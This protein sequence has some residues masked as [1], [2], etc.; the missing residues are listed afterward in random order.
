[1]Y[2]KPKRE[3]VKGPFRLNRYDPQLSGCKALWLFNEGA[4]DTIYNHIRDAHHGIIQVSS[5]WTQSDDGLNI[6]DQGGLVYCPYDDELADLTHITLF[7]EV[8]NL[9]NGNPKFL[10]SI[11][12]DNSTPNHIKFD[13][14][15]GQADNQETDFIV[16]IGG[17]SAG[18]TIVPPNNTFT[19]GD[20]YIV[21][22]VYDGSGERMY[23]KSGNGQIYSTTS[24]KTGT[25][26]HGTTA[27]L[28][29]GRSKTSDS[30]ADVILYQTRLYDVGLEESAIHGILDDYYRPFH[31]PIPYAVI[32]TGPTN[33]NVT[34]DPLTTIE[35]ISGNSIIAVNVDASALPTV[36]SLSATQSTVT[37]ILITADA[38]ASLE[39]LAGN[40]IISVNKTPTAL[41][42]V[43]SLSGVGSTVTNINI[44]ADSLISIESITGDFNTSVN[45]TAGVLSSIESI[46][47]TVQAGAGVNITADPLSS[48]E[49]IT[50]TFNT[51]VLYSA[52][53]LNSTESLNATVQIGGTVNV[54]ADPLISVESINGNVILSVNQTAQVLG[55][56]ES[57]A[58]SQFVKVDYSASPLGTIESINANNITA[59]YKIANP[60]ETTEYIN[61]SVSGEASITA[62]P[63]E[64]TESITGNQIIGVFI[65]AS[66]MSTQ[67]ALSGGYYTSVYKVGALSTTESL[68]GI[69]IGAGPGSLGQ[70]QH[71]K[72]FNNLDE[73]LVWEPGSGFQVN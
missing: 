3:K 47:G 45:Q 44:T 63:L 70:I 71:V 29:F 69:G 19:L 6:P 30:N 62:D 41:S 38:L 7:C 72:L 2:L 60:L 8:E 20:I 37:N 46:S 16:S 61:G 4:G 12:G 73:I 35:S 66:D 52:T 68:A 33:V 58:G 18:S 43:G 5:D 17:S 31:R 27:S 14:S 13:A 50:G 59:V 51:S 48:T 53:A 24:A 25:L 22:Y 10:G 32:A 65:T 39:A 11:N 49:S 28:L 54:I 42:D 57:I 26:S 64:T 67:E 23:I 34:A 15:G 1:M 21:C 36:E 40:F 9:S 55:S 56:T